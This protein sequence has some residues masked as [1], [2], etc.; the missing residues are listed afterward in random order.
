MNIFLKNF[1]FIDEKLQEK[2]KTQRILSLGC[3][4]SSQVVILAV[5]T[6][7]CKF[8]LVDG[9]TVEETNLNRQ[10]FGKNDVGVNKTKALQRK[11]LEINSDA[12]IE[13]VPHMLT[14]KETAN[15]LISKTDFVINTVD[16]ND[17]IYVINEATH[18][19]EKA[20]IFPLNL[21]FG[22]F[23]LFF[24]KKEKTMLTQLTNG[25]YGVDAYS[26]IILNTIGIENVSENFLNTIIE[27]KLLDEGDFPQLGIATYL[28]AALIVNAMI[29]YVKEEDVELVNYFDPRKEV[30]K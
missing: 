6:G 20:E 14:E 21:G 27:S 26:N 13:V 29:K 30:K 15:N 28:N 24:G 2:I 17:M 16:A 11:I 10:A 5:R 3:G 25:K 18:R 4:L 1:L 12:E 8:I 7:F 19:Q 9:D 23:F 22:S